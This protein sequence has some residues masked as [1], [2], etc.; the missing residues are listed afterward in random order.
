MPAP[1]IETS[2]QYRE[3]CSRI[4]ALETH[5]R[6]IDAARSLALANKTAGRIATADL[7]DLLPLEDARSDVAYTLRGLVQ[8]A[9]EWETR[10]YT[11]RH[12]P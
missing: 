7:R 9:G 2:R 5:V 3:L 11:K 6:A 12:S 10:R 1:L 4:A 8:A